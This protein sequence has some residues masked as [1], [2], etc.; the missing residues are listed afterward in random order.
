MKDKS[1][2][3]VIAYQKTMETLSIL[4]DL[5]SNEQ[6]TPHDLKNLNTKL[7]HGLEKSNVY[8]AS[9]TGCFKKEVNFGD[10]YLPC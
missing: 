10:R 5:P 7:F 1:D 6:F 8:K 4:N 9:D 3:G 2:L